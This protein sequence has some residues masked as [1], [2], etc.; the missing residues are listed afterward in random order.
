ML[1]LDASLASEERLAAVVAVSGFLFAVE[2]WAR[3]LARRHRGLRVLQ[4]RWCRVGW[5]LFSLEVL[6]GGRSPHA[7]PAGDAMWIPWTA[8]DR[9]VRVRVLFVVSPR[10]ARG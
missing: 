5:T 4:A 3:R 7:R 1:A 9:H 2:E 8:V 10:L 6:G